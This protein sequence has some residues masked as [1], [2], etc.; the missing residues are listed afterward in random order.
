[1]KYRVEV[2]EPPRRGNPE[3]ARFHL[4]DGWE[5]VGWTNDVSEAQDWL[6]GFGPQTTARVDDRKRV[7]R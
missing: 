3:L 1:M 7:R 2:K 4:K 6:D 5:L